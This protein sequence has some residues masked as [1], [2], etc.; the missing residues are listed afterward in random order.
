MLIFPDLSV[1]RRE[2]LLILGE[3]GSGKTTLLHL[4]AGLLDPLT[5]DI[6]IGGRDITRLPT[7]QR[8]Y[9]R[10]SHVG[11]VF[12]RSHFIES[13][14]VFDNL[15]ISPFPLQRADV[16]ERARQLGLEHLLDKLPSQLSSGEQQRVSIA[17]AVLHRPTLILAD[18]P[19]S[20]LDRRNCM[21]VMEIMQEQANSRDA[22]L[23]IVTHDDRLAGHGT[24]E[25]ELKIPE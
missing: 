6:V 3:S 24:Q 8:D 15:V 16:F 19:T 4:L 17:R 14:S 7:D 5:G 13:L 22:V 25:V 18:E 1:R 20:A 12:Q 10:G 9:F 21:S 23:I 2:T 11:M